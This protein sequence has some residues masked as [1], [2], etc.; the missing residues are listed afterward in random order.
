LGSTG[1]PTGFWLEELAA[2]YY[3]LKDAGFD[4][5]LAT[6]KGGKPPIDPK[7][8]DKGMQTDHTKRFNADSEA[9]RAL[10]TTKKLADMDEGEFAAIFYPGGH[11][12][13]WD[14]AEDP[15]SFWLIEKFARAKKPIAAVCHGPAVF[16]KTPSVVRGMKVTAFTNEEEVQVQ[17]EKIVPFL[18]EDMLK[19]HGAKF[20]KGPA[21]Q[22][23]VVTD[24]NSLLIT[25]Q[26]PASSEEVAKALIK[27]L[28][29]RI[30]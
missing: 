29:G 15:N 1:K 28:R 22:P 24:N 19:E 7:S 20:S 13:L 5:V 21:W 11:G 6:P 25:G 23:Y 16:K 4:I 2:P 10:E 17:L 12:P 14:L 18:V 3:A 26:N 9:K 8:E 27:K 30:F